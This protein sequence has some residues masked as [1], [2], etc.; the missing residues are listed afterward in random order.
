MTDELAGKIFAKQARFRAA[1][2]RREP[3]SGTDLPQAEVPY[4][5]YEKQDFLNEVYM[6]EVRFD[7]LVSLLKNK[8]NLI[9]QGAPGVGKTFA[10]RRLAYAMMGEKDDSRIQFVQFHQSYSYE[11]F[12]LG[13]KPDG[14]GFVLREGVFYRFCN[15]A[16]EDKDRPYFFLIDEINRGNMSK[17]LVSY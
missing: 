17:I 8:K 5:K 12:M 16:R 3:V 2:R 6:D 15:R 13:Y 14:D 10:A 9:L 7:A 4:E 1:E 11:D